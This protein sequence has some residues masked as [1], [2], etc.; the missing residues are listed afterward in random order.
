MMSLF[1]FSTSPFS[2]IK[3]AAYLF[4]LVAIM[5]ISFNPLRPHAA[6]PVAVEQDGATAPAAMFELLRFGRPSDEVLDDLPAIGIPWFLRRA[7]VTGEI[8][9]SD[10]GQ[11]VITLT[12]NGQTVG[13]YVE[14]VLPIDADRARL[15]LAF[16]PTDMALV[17]RLAEPIDTTLDPLSLLRVTGAEHVRSSLDHDEFRVSVLK[18]DFPGFILDA[19]FGAVKHRPNRNSD[20]F[21]LERGESEGAAIRKAYRDEAIRA[22][23]DAPRL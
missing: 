17:R 8:G 10:P 15:Y 5:G 2:K 20:T 19:I 6:K 7:G 13:R 12:L 22:G 3:F 18:P 9:P 4:G 16:E 14:R 21:P 11:V 1:A 23:A